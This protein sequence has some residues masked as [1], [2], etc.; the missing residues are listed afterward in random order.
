M[1]FQ[2]R[3]TGAII[4][5]ILSVLVM[6]LGVAMIIECIVFSSRTT[7]LNANLGDF[8]EANDFASTIFYILILVS[9]VAVFMGGCG[10]TCL[11]KPC[12]KSRFWVITF[13]ITLVMVWVVFV[14]IGA[15]VAAVATNGPETV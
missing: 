2:D 5:A 9:I 11:A 4:V 14:V 12:V 1:C 7:V 3:K 8:K 15:V 13:G 6:L 10:L